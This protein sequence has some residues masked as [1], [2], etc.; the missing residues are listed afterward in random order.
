VPNPT[1]KTESSNVISNS[2]PTKPSLLP[3]GIKVYDTPKT[4]VTEPTI[5]DHSISFPETGFRIPLSLWGIFSYFPTIKPTSSLM[6]D[7]EE[8]YL[9]TPSRWNPHD[10]AYA[11][12]EENMLDW[13]G[14]MV[15][16]K[17]RVQVLLADIAEE[18]KTQLSRLPCKSQ[19][20]K[21]P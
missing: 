3:S 12:N 16:K 18:P 19:A 4:Q 5:E 17:D 15:T 6:M 20:S 2:S 7:T 13:E 11:T 14:N 8:V 10:D 1:T 21:T 9:L